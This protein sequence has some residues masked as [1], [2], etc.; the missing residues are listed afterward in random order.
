VALNLAGFSKRGRKS[1]PETNSESFRRGMAAWKMHKGKKKSLEVIFV[2]LAKI[3]K[4][5]NS[6]IERDY[7]KFKRWLK[8]SGK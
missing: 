1:S 3:E 4:K 6:T 8:P 2:E 5:S 7:K